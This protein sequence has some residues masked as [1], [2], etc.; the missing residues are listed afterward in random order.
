MQNC[1]VTV[2]LFEIT[3]LTKTR[4][5]RGQ[6]D[7]YIRL[8]AWCVHCTGP[9]W[10]GSQGERLPVS[11]YLLTNI[12]Q[13][14][15]LPACNHQQVPFAYK[16]FS[17]TDET[18]W[19]QSTAFKKRLSRRTS[20]SS[21]LVYGTRCIVTHCRV[22]ECMLLIF[23]GTPVAS[24]SIIPPADSP[25][26]RPIRRPKHSDTSLPRQAPRQVQGELGG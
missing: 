11:S 6:Q 15:L 17:R 16:M 10:H 20:I 21:S 23:T 4:R 8:L 18:R 19:Q 25:S 9:C 24:V 14:G 26:P 2:F 12:P 1:T 22:I 5:H 13:A 3:M 7:L